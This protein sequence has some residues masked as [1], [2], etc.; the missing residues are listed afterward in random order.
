MATDASPATT[1]PAALQLEQ[2]APPFEGLS[3]HG[4]VRL[5]DYAGRWLVFFAHP[6]DFTPV[7][8]SE[9]VAFARRAEEFRALDCELLGLSVDSVYAHLAWTE[10]IREHFGVSIPFPI[11]ADVSTQIARRYGMMSGESAPLTT[12]RALFIIDPRSILRAML[13][14][15]NSTGRSVDEV[16]RMLQALQVADRAHV[17]TPEGWL[18]GQETVEPAPTTAADLD[19]RRGVTYGCVDWYYYRRPAQSGAE[20]TQGGSADTGSAGAG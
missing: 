4:P 3:T 10:S 19:T 7:C 20:T 14:Y 12:V 18:P 13:Y 1:P 8:A 6:A 5:S 11:L 2:P 9:F 17:V 15:P 16:L